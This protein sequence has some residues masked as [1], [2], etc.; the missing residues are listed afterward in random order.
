MTV[1]ILNQLVLTNGGQYTDMRQGIIIK[2]AVTP[3][4]VPDQQAFKHI[5][6]GQGMVFGDKAY[7]LKPAQEVM[8]DKGCH[9]GAIMKNNMRGKNKDK[10][11]WLSKVRAPFENLFSKNEKRARYRGWAKVQ[12][13]AFLEAIVH[14]TKRLITVN[15]DPLFCE[16]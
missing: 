11:K 1:K 9:S 7:S 13:Q 8:K 14:N 4:N 10:D 3:A 16:A 5:C 15:C 12:L 6:P 2:L